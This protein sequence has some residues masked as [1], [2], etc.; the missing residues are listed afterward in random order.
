MKFRLFLTICIGIN[1]TL[2]LKLSYELNILFYHGFIAFLLSLGLLA[3]SDRFIK[4]EK[5]IKEKK[6]ERTTF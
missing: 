1:L 2:L 4:I 6:N 3:V 5:G